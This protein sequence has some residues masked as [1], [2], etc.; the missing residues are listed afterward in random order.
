MRQDVSG[1][2]MD[3]MRRG[4]NLHQDPELGK[5]RKVLEQGRWDQRRG[6]R[7]LCWGEGGD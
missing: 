3:G 1:D 4:V 7:W 2:S 5:A 6:E